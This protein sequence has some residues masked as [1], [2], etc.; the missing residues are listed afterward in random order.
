MATPS[1]VM[2]TT[3]DAPAYAQ[4]LQALKT[5]LQRTLARL[6]TCSSP[7]QRRPERASGESPA[8]SPTPA[9]HGGAGQPP[10]SVEAQRLILHE[11]VVTA[12]QR[13]RAEMLLVREMQRGTATATAA[14]APV[15]QDEQRPPTQTGGDVSRPP[16][17]SRSRQR[18]RADDGRRGAAQAEIASLRARRKQILRQIETASTSRQRCRREAAPSES[19]SPSPS[20]SAE[21]SAPS[22]PEP[23]EFSIE[24]VVR[25]APL[26][27]SLSLTPRASLKA[28]A[29]SQRPSALRTRDA[30]GTASLV[31]PPPPATTRRRRAK[32][33][34]PPSDTLQD[35]FS[36]QLKFAETMLQLE[37]S[38][39]TRE[40][41]LGASQ[42]PA[43]LSAFAAHRRPASHRSSR[44]RGSAPLE[45][46]E[47]LSDSS[48]FFE[49][50]DASLESATDQ[51]R[52]RRWQHARR[53]YRTPTAAHASA[54]TRSTPSTGGSTAQSSSTPDSQPSPPQS[55]PSDEGFRTPEQL[56]PPVPARPSKSGHK[57]CGLETL[58]EEREA[59]QQLASADVA[60]PVTVHHHLAPKKT[61]P[62][63]GKQVR[64]HGDSEYPTPLV[65]RNISFSHES[66]DSSSEADSTTHAN[67]YARRSAVAVPPERPGARLQLSDEELLSFVDDSS[68]ASGELS[69]ESF[70]RAFQALRRE[71]RDDQGL[72]LDPERGAPESDREGGEAELERLEAH[73]RRLESN[74]HDEEEGEGE[75]V[76]EEVGEREEDR[77]ALRRRRRQVALSIQERTAAMVLQPADAAASTQRKRLALELARLRREL[78]AIDATLATR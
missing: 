14:E 25:L 78:Q 35:V 19:S 33:S 32:E 2:S 63:S 5:E 4:E 28:P 13:R 52:R 23:N 46:S 1:A 45:V 65:A 7:P 71:V 74:Q 59:S 10:L 64:F 73:R 36:L 50:D 16:L 53:R 61:P 21:S 51:E 56:R 75:V 8:P 44:S 27:D 66:M 40:R 70:L 3:R 77:E 62:D 31:S 39:Q 68:V 29:T 18:R 60:T 26:L 69:D 49:D 41:L 6:E 72:A 42:P 47:D 54:A 9:A 17:P 76:E 20:G 43:P 30:I 67:S 22:S 34:M 12:R 55:V 24:G 57:R 58:D 48:A 15:Q 37:K 11:L 38:I